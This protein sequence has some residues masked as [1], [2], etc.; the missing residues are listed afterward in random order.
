MTIMVVDEEMDHGPILT[1]E[2]LKVK[3]EKFRYGELE[4]KLA[5]MGGRL[6]AEVIPQWIM[7][8]IEPVE[9]E[10]SKATHCEKI[11]K[12]DGLITEEDS[13]EE[14]FRKVRAF[15]PWPGAYFF[16]SGKRII[17]TEAEMENGK[18]IIKRVKPE[19]KKEMPLEDFLR[20]NKNAEEYIKKL[21]ENK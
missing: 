19:G 2:K 14:V 13:P 8:R 20:G 12:Q 7:G 6:L 3:S 4:E 15:T 1:S 10:H 11:T 17:I 21:V 16:A 9:Q 18:L 5:R